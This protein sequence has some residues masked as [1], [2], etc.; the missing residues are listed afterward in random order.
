MRETQVQEYCRPFSARRCTG[1][2]RCLEEHPLLRLCDAGA[3]I[4]LNTENPAMFGCTLVGEYRTAARA[5]GFS[6]RKLRGVAEN[7]FRYAFR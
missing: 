5:F 3:P 4:V 1:V 7:R 6:E 2:V